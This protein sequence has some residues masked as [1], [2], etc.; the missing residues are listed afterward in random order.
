M[1]SALGVSM[2]QLVGKRGLLPESWCLRAQITLTGEYG[3]TPNRPLQSAL[4]SGS[5]RRPYLLF[6]RNAFIQ[7]WLPPPLR[8][9]SAVA[10]LG[11][12]QMVLIQVCR[13]CRVCLCK[14]SKQGLEIAQ[15]QVEVP[16][17]VAGVKTLAT[18][19]LATHTGSGEQP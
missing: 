15:A 10:I 11:G 12:T 13:V 14:Q 8:R 5:A 3:N 6:S 2:R 18:K 16:T 19:F 4:H 1:S 17:T 9:Q 7:V